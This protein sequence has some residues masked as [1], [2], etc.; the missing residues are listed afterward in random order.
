MM[1][2]GQRKVIA[3]R[4]AFELRPNQVV[5]W[6][7]GMPEVWPGWPMK[8]VPRSSDPDGEPGVIGGMRTAA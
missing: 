2:L 5:T 7:S 4:P 6:A 8:K 3:R 1:E